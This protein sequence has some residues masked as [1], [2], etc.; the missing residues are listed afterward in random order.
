[1]TTTWT[2]ELRAKVTKMY[3]NGEPTAENSMEI[4]KE[5]ADSIDVSANGV[6]MVLSKAGVYILKTP[7]KKTATATSGDKPARVSKESAHQALT[8]ALEAHSQTVDAEII[9]KLTGK[10]AMYFAEVLSNL[11]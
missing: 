6:R 3:L 10:A 4:V 7:A 9:G 1:M 11:K 8:E 5:I 2:D